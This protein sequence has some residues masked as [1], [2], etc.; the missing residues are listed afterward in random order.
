[1]S[2]PKNCPERAFFKTNLSTKKS[3]TVSNG[4][5]TS[6]DCGYSHGSILADLSRSGSEDS[7]FGNYG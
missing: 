3:S 1:M 5:F 7:S 4:T 6:I 2:K